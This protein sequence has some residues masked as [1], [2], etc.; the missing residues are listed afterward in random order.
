MA[1]ARRR[2]GRTSAANFGRLLDRLAIDHR[3]GVVARSLRKAAAYDLDNGAA[4]ASFVYRLTCGHLVQVV[5]RPL[6]PNVYGLYCE[7]D[8]CRR[9]RDIAEQLL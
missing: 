6:P 8:G 5:S 4:L 7:K 3:D 1:E 2:R 9:T